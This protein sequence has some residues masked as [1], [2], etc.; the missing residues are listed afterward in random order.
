MEELS[1]IF[2]SVGALRVLVVFF[3]FTT[4][5]GRGQRYRHGN[6]SNGLLLIGLLCVIGFMYIYN[7][8]NTD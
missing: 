2:S 1:R 3:V 4:F 6:A 8:S 7:V 5:L